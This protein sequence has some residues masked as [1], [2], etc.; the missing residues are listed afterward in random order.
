[1]R[2]AA[3][4][5]RAAAQAA[6]ATE[7]MRRGVHSSGGSVGP[8]GALEEQQQHQQ[9]QHQQPQQQQEL[10][11]QEQEAEERRPQKEREQQQD[12]QQERQAE[13]EQEQEQDQEQERQLHQQQLMSAAAAAFAAAAAAGP[14]KDAASQLRGNASPTASEAA[15]TVSAQWRAARRLVAPTAVGPQRDEFNDA[16]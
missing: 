13:R 7:R 15:S 16:Q 9:Q 14:S 1:M 3:A 10:G 2:G 4:G 6:V 5:M 11:E 8:G 12:Q